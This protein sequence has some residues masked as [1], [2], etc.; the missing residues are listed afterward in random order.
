MHWIQGC[1]QWLIN[2]SE[3]HLTGLEAKKLYAEYWTKYF[4][5]SIVRSPISRFISMLKFPEHFG[6]ETGADGLLEIKSYIARF[7]PEPTLEHDHRYS[8]RESLLS[9][10]SELCYHFQNG[11]LYGNML[12]N[13]VDRIF[14]YEEI[15]GMV[16]ELAKK[17]GLDATEFPCL[18]KSQAPNVDKSIIGNEVESL[19][20][21]MHN[22]DYK[23]YGL[24]D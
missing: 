2:P 8:S 19:I 24:P 22:A 17:L 9:L 10:S 5:F 11:S 7:G 12:G 23:L 3:K 21:S 13:E 6:V 14:L 15:E 18:E 1:D 20:Q 4:K 16:R